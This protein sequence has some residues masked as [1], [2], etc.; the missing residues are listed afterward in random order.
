MKTNIL[1]IVMTATLIACIALSSCSP[2]SSGTMSYNYHKM[3]QAKKMK[4]AKC[5][6]MKYH[7]SDRKRGL[8][9]M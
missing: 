8:S 4:M 9:N 1:L 2:K 6:A 7:N 5:T 3:S